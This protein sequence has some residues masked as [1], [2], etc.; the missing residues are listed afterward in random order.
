MKNVAGYDISR[1][2]T[3]SMGTLG[4]ILDVSLKVMPRPTTELT[5][6]LDM[7]SQEA[8]ELTTTMRRANFPLS[9]TCYFDGCLYLRLS[10]VPSHVFASHRKIGGEPLNNADQFWQ[11]LRNQT[12]IFPAI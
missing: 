9:A 11:A 4:V 5:L 12:R 8:F 10:G 7:P 2:I 3:G 6:T 1:L